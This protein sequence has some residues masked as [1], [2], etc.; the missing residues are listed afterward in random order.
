VT[1]PAEQLL[2]RAI[3]SQQAQEWLR[4]LIG[5]FYD[6]DARR[7]IRQAAPPTVDHLGIEFFSGFE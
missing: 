5:S 2:Q 6:R 4:E 1:K 7:N 3:D